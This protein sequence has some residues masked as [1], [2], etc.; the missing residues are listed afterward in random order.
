MSV[1]AAGEV[2]ARSY[3]PRIQMQ[4]LMHFASAAYVPHPLVPI[5]EGDLAMQIYAL[6]G[7]ACER[8]N[9]VVA[10]KYGIPNDV[11]S[12]VSQAIE[13]EVASEP[14]LERWPREVATWMFQLAA[15][16]ISHDVSDACRLT[17]LAEVS[18]DVRRHAWLCLGPASAAKR[19][20]APTQSR[21]AGNVHALSMDL[22]T[23]FR[24]HGF[25]PSGIEFAQL[26]SS[27]QHLESKVK[28]D[29]PPASELP[30]TNDPEDLN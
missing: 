3:E 8:V 13:A 25:D 5:L 15:V 7:E 6:G 12:I 30:N 24:A 26:L 19:G 10:S 2:R 9:A 21:V 18:D 17:V 16:L 27:V 28:S 11:P 23:V 29:P 14:L 20:T 1:M 4:A 22:Q